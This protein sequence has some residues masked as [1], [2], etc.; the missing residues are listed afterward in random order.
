MLRW[1]VCWLGYVVGEAVLWFRACDMDSSLGCFILVYG[2]ICR[3]GLQI[4][5]WDGG[6]GYGRR[7]LLMF[8][9]PDK[10]AVAGPSCHSCDPDSASPVVDP[11]RR[12]RHPAVPRQYI[13]RLGDMTGRRGEF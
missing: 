3:W 13:A 2:V 7:G 12:R 1:D 6:G 4:Q 5:Q 9:V 10:V 8:G 11:C